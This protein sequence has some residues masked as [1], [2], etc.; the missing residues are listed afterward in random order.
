MSY[1]EDQDGSDEVLKED[2]TDLERNEGSDDDGGFGDEF[3]EFEAGADDDDFGDFD[4]GIQ[5]ASDLRSEQIA[6]EPQ[7]PPAPVPESPFVSNY[8]LAIPKPHIPL[9]QPSAL[10]GMPADPPFFV[11]LDR[12]LLPR[13]LGRPD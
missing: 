9:P 13:N 11:A 4:E 10:E 3:D 7:R 2:A 12:L 5:Q 1:D 6:P 8:T